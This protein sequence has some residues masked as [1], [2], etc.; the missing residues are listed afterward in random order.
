MGGVSRELARRLPQVS[1]FQRNV[2]KL[3]SS[4]LPYLSCVSAS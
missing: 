4:P 2:L 1:D 3:R